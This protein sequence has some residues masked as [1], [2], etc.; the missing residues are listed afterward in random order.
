MKATVLALALLAA[1]AGLAPTASMAGP[2]EGRHMDDLATLLDLTEAQKVQ[3]SAILQEEHQKMR[4]SFDQAKASGAKPD[5]EQMRALHQQI[6]QELVQ[7]LTPVLSAPQ[8][9]K[10]QILERMHGGHGHFGP[11]GPPPDA[12]PPS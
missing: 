9:Q 1:G 10:F 12:R 6:H 5:F 3:V 2:P 11:G 4:D 7:K 8:L